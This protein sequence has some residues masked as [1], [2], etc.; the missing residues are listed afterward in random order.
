MP[1]RSPLKFNVTL[2]RDNITPA[3]AGY[4]RRKCRLMLAEMVTIETGC[5]APQCRWHAV[6]APPRSPRPAPDVTH[7]SCLLSPPAT[8][9]MLSPQR[10]ATP[11][12]RASGASA[13]AHVVV[14]D[15]VFMPRHRCATASLF[16]MSVVLM[17]RFR[18]ARRRRYSAVTRDLPSLRVTP[19]RVIATIRAAAADEKDTYAPAPW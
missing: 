4:A 16:P 9:L 3:I 1:Q 10:C 19:S 18:A 2:S 12:R 13:V 6:A 11:A 17:L 7:A 8:P 15:I 14:V 5:Y